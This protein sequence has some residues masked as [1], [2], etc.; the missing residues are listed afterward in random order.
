MK[1]QKC[2]S[3]KVLSLSAKCDD[4]CLVRYKEFEKEGYPPDTSISGG[5]YIDIDFCLECG[6]VQG[7]FPDYKLD[8]NSFNEIGGA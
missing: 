3:N 6:Q 8:L 4:R 1:C 5:D 2:K 7:E